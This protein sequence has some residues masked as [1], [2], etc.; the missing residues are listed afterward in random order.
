MKATALLNLS[1]T[2][3]LLAGGLWL[4]GCAARAEN[5]NRLYFFENEKRAIIVP[6][7]INDSVR[8]EY[9]LIDTGAAS[10]WVQ[11]DSTFCATHPLSAWSDPVW[12]GTGP[13]TGWDRESDP[14]VGKTIYNTP[15]TITM[16][17]VDMPFERVYTVDGSQRIGKFDATFSF[18]AQDT[19]HVWEMNFRHNYLE[20]HDAAIFT[21][22]DDCRVFP[23]VDIKGNY[24]N[25]RFP[26]K[27]TCADGA[28]IT[29]DQTYFIDTG[30]LCDLILLESA[31]EYGF[32]RGRD[33]AVLLNHWNNRRYEVDAE[34]FDGMRLDAMRVY[35]N[36][37]SY[38]LNEE[39]AKG[40]IG[41]N[42]MKRFNVFFDLS[43]KQIGFQPI[44]GFKRTVN[45]DYTRKYFEAQD[46][47]LITEVLDIPDN[48]YK[49]AGVMAGDV[50]MAI[51][52]KEMKTAS[53]ADFTEIRHSKVRRMDIIRNGKTMR[54]TVRFKE[55]G[56]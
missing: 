51:N 39:E 28:T 20:A 38:M 12:S 5:P 40:T 7:T 50:V 9:A 13:M 54:L 11:M 46:N 1:A 41:L 26:V 10:S 52:G 25:V 31:A 3:A 15:L 43:K 23:L 37:G 30:A 22:P 32:F 29:I 56:E 36:E 42:F 8:V 27:V 18:S 49:K 53:M 19:T 34:V 45:I 55:L 24:M 35:L 48:P 44:R 33:D 2:I 14:K 16:C 47:N 4:S 21:M 17:G 6:V